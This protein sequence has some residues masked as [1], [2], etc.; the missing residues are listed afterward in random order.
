MKYIRNNLHKSLLF[1]VFI[2]TVGNLIGSPAQIIQPGAPGNP[3]KILNAEEA[4]AIA[5]TSYIEADVKF[6]QGMIV[7]HEQ[8]I[9]MS[10]M[11]DQ[12]TNNKT[13]LDLARR[14][15]VSQKDEIS[16]MESWLKDRG[17]YQKVNP[18]SYTHLTL[19][20]K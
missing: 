10:E 1:L 17:E 11:A 5:N 6:L 8:A 13:I 20:T 19:P 9:V 2:F 14:I 15:D 7:H 18:V 12:R 3:S 4:T 16:F